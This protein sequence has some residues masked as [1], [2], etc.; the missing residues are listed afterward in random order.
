MGVL[1]VDFYLPKYRIAIELDGPSHFIIRKDRSLTLSGTSLAKQRVM[2]KCG[3][4][5][6]IFQAVGNLAQAEVKSVEDVMEEI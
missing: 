6:R 1:S 5:D 4:F 2:A 3:Q